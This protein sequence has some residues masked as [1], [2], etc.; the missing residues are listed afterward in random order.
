MINVYD[1]LRWVTYGS[2]S[3]VNY[4]PRGQ[5]YMM[6]N[7]FNL[8]NNIVNFKDNPGSTRDE[9]F[10]GTCVSKIYIIPAL[11]VKGSFC[12]FALD[13]SFFIWK[14]NYRLDQLSL[15]SMVWTISLTRYNVYV[16]LRGKG[17]LQ[18]IL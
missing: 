11:Q 1:V 6:L 18:G 4:G 14:N 5:S 15:E 17:Q 3:K 7:K 16:T 12:P 9:E 2:I 8:C 13:N 10:I